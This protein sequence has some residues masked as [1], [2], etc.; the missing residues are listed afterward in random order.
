MKFNSQKTK[1]PKLLI[2]VNM[3]NIIFLYFIIFL[4][5]QQKI[6]CSFFGLEYTYDSCN[7]LMIWICTLSCR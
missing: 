1:K 4:W 5:N 3:K 6:I 2:T 7:K